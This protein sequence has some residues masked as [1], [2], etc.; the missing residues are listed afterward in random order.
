MQDYKRFLIRFCIVVGFV[1]GF[2]TAM[3]LFWG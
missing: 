1:L 2:L 3:S